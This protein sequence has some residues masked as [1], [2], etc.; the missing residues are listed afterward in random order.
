MCSRH[1][2]KDS[3]RA[4]EECEHVDT[5]HDVTRGAETRPL[6]SAE[7]FVQLLNQHCSINN[8]GRPR[9]NEDHHAGP[10]SSRDIR[11]EQG[12]LA[13]GKARCLKIN[14]SYTATVDTSE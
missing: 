9:F 8:L 13:R 1:I 7:E 6:H 5:F 10:F 11:V 14:R 2:S 3:R 4:R 12:S